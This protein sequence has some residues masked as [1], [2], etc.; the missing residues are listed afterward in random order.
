[1]S[2]PASPPRFRA[3]PGSPPAGGGK[4]CL[5]VE[6]RRTD[7]PEDGDLLARARDGDR[8]ALGALYDR[9]AARAYSLAHRLVGAP[10]AADVVQDCF[11]ALLERPAGFD[12]A[13]GSF[14]AWFLA[15]VHH[16]AVNLLRRNRARPG[17]GELEQLADG[18]SSP[19]EVTWQRL[20]ASAVRE[21]LAQMPPEQRELL[22]LAYYHGLTQRELAMRFSLPLGTV[23]ARMRRGL[24]ALRGPLRAE[25]PPSE[26]ETGA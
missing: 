25:G 15:S 21:A 4:E 16:R 14:P 18:G 13:R 7:D 24:A 17:D 26:K 22:V 2:H 9:H 6:Q 8:S 10:A 19:V 5:S 3:V 20:R 12:P 11:L 1:M 23:K